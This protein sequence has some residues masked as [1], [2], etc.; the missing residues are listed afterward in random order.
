[1]ANIGVDSCWV[2]VL[3]GGTIGAIL[4]M[5]GHSALKQYGAFQF[6]GELVY[7]SM[8]REFGSIISAI[9]VIARA[10][11]AMTAE[12]GSMNISEQI[13]AL[14]TLSIDP[15]R[16][17]VVPRVVASSFILPFLSLFCVLFGVG[18]GYIESVW[19]L[20]VNAEQYVDSIKTN[21]VLGDITKGLVKA[22]IFG[23]L[24]SLICTYKGIH[25][26]GGARGIGV[27][28]TEAVV[29]SCVTV[30][31]ANFILSAILF[32]SSH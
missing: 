9:M 15:V 13:D 27:A 14:T 21:V 2:V 23:L 26:R 4:A 17:V 11:S 22:A 20:E 7:I 31:L 19:V 29:Y 8:T 1:M 30:F 28:T 24:S 5:H 6:L 16:Y 25:A 18:A 3:T 32:N 12:I 10:G